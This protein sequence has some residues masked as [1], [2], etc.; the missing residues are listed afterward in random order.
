MR[1]ASLFHA[2]GIP[3]ARPRAMERPHSTPQ[4]ETKEAE[5]TEH[6]DRRTVPTLPVTSE[7]GDEGGSYAEPTLQVATR[8]GDVSASNEPPAPAARV[9]PATAADAEPPSMIR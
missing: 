8:A 1:L 7:V 2:R 3:I 5:M 9:S 4:R 6:T